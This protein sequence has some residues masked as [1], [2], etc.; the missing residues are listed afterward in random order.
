M[1]K[2]EPIAISPNFHDDFD[3]RAHQSKKLLHSLKMSAHKRAKISKHKELAKH[4]EKELDGSCDRLLQEMVWLFAWRMMWWWGLTFFCFHQIKVSASKITSQPRFI[5]GILH[6]SM[7][8]TLPLVLRRLSENNI[9]SMPVTSRTG[10]FMNRFVDLWDLVKFIA[11][12]FVDFHFRN[13]EE[14]FV[15]ESFYSESHELFISINFFQFSP[16]FQSQEINS[17]KHAQLWSLG[18]EESVPIL[19]TYSLFF[20]MEVLAV[21]F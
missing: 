4:E 5:S 20:A 9:S 14:V 1:L 7:S 10:K 8:D 21:W 11:S 19:E 2:H 15:S 3:A 17:W 6:C 12:T 16:F 18:L 13:F